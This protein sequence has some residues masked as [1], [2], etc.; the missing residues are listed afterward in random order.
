[1]DKKQLKKVTAKVYEEY[2]FLKNDKYYYLDSDDVLI[3]SVFSQY[4]E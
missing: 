1:M 2:G 3:C 4:T